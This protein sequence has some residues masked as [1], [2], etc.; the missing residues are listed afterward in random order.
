[1]M[2]DDTYVPADCAGPFA[3]ACFSHASLG[4]VTNARL[5]HDES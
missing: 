1:M 5:N 4:V 3:P 2:P